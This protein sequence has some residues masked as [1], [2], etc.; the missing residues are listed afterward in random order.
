[1]DAKH[2]VI[3]RNLYRKKSVMMVRLH[4]LWFVVRCRETGRVYGV[5]CAAFLR[6]FVVSVRRFWR[7]L[8]GQD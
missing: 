2:E 5:I 6:S 3:E 4:K 1:M 7:Q 8:F